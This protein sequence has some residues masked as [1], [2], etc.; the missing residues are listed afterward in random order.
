MRASVEQLEE[1]L[2]NLHHGEEGGEEAPPRGEFLVRR[3]CSAGCEGD[4][5]K[6][7]PTFPESVSPRNVYALTP[8][9]SGAQSPEGLQEVKIS[10]FTLPAQ[11]RSCHF[12]GVEFA[13]ISL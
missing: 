11:T 2:Q 4:I 6:V 3:D 13:C 8:L 1:A 10:C 5:N 12:A 7:N 9:P